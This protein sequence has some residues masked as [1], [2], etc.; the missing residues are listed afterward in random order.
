[1]R[2][3][4]KYKITGPLSTFDGPAGARPLRA[5]MQ[6]DGQPVL[7]LL[8]S[9]GVPAVQYQVKLFATGGAIEDDAGEYVDTITVQGPSGPFVAHIFFKQAEVL[10]PS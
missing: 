5:L 8:C 1:M 3:I 2:V 10:F 9:W 7:Y 6:S 4:W